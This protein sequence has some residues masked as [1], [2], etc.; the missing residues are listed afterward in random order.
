MSQ[1]DHDWKLLCVFHP[2]MGKVK[3]MSDEEEEEMFQEG[4][5]HLK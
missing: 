4:K 2:K 3:I 1:G 5:E